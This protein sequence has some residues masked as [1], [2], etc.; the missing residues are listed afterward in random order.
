MTT[1]TIIAEA[2]KMADINGG[3]DHYVI[4]YLAGKCVVLADEVRRL[5]AQLDD[6]DDTSDEIDLHFLAESCR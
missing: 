6:Q 4:G 5:R 2:R 3:N 1:E